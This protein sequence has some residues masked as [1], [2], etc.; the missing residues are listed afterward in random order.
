MNGNL[1]YDCNR[2]PS[3]KVP[4]YLVGLNLTGQLVDTL[5]RLVD[6]DVKGRLV[7]HDIEAIEGRLVG[8]N[9]KGQLDDCD[10]DP[11][12]KVRLVDQDIV[13]RLVGLDETGQLV[14]NDI[15]H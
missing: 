11:I 5:H 1:Q 9:M 4:V 7:D 13:C 12:V 6:P 3:S 2:F 14:A 10:M 15:V 8:L